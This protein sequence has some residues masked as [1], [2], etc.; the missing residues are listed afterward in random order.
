MIAS[1]TAAMLARH[2]EAVTLR[3]PGTPNRDVTV[4]A[5]RF[6][7][8]GGAVGDHLVGTHGQNLVRWLIGN[9]E[10]R[11]RGWPGP[12]RQGDL[13]IDAAGRTWTLEG[14]ADTRKDRGRTIVHFMV[15][16][17]GD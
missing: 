5:K 14:H 1:R 11:R 9:A 7:E 4:K 15:G 10:I 6:N 13:L 16:K 17:G 3:R 2:G 12:P 8:P